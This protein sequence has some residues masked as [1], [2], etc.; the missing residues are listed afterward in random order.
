[1]LWAAYALP[2]LLKVLRGLKNSWKGHVSR[3]L[4]LRRTN[5]VPPFSRHSRTCAITC[6]FS[7]GKSKCCFSHYDGVKF[8][9]LNCARGGHKISMELPSE[10]ESKK[11]VTVHSPIKPFY[12]ESTG[13][14]LCMFFRV[15]ENM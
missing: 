15:E 5:Y 4:C 7:V 3:P 2:V 6:V 9:R 11:C 8:T 12:T 10:S 14:E 1:M 13:T